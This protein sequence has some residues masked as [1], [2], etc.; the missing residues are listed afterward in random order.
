[1][2]ENLLKECELIDEHC[3]FNAEIHHIIAGDEQLLEKVSR[4]VPAI[5]TAIAGGFSVRYPDVAWL[6]WVTVTGAVTTAISSACGFE[7]SYAAHLDA[8]KGFTVLKHEARALRMTFNEALN[9]TDL[10]IEVR[11][12]LDRYLELVRSAPPT[13]DRAFKKAR[14]RIENDGRHKSV[15]QTLSRS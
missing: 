1:M 9:D 13:T 7:K 5:C 2:R 11:K 15:E 8:A 10:G 6:D 4:V 12:L 14:K 3:T